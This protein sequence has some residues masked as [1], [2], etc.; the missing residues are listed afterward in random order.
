MLHTI[1]LLA[2][3]LTMVGRDRTLVLEIALSEDAMPLGFVGPYED[4]CRT[5]DGFFS[6]AAFYC[7]FEE[8]ESLIR[9]SGGRLFT[10]AS[11]ALPP[12]VMVW[13]REPLGVPAQ[14]VARRPA[15]VGVWWRV[16]R[17]HGQRQGSACLLLPQNNNSHNEPLL[18]QL[19]SARFFRTVDNLQNDPE[20]ASSMRDDFPF[21]GHGSSRHMGPF[22]PWG[23]E[24]E[25]PPGV[26]TTTR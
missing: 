6:D 17:L 23:A 3:M 25:R 13:Y 7:G 4:A 19:E 20:S 9:A 15:N 11:T 1:I 10:V 22:I 26:P 24:E 16:L 12:E 14:P 2:L 18:Y 5:L 8:R 21:F